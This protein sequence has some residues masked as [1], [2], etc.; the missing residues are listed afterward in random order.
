MVRGTRGVAAAGDE[1]GHEVAIRRLILRPCELF[2][3][4]C[5]CRSV[6]LS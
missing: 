3:V 4:S 1:T 5:C 6:G 2:C